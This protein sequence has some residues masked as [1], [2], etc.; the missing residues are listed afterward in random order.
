[1]LLRRIAAVLSAA[2]FSY[3]LKADDERVQS[4]VYLQF[5]VPTRTRT[6]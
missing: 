1:M 6:R 5:I 3:A 2:A 4:G